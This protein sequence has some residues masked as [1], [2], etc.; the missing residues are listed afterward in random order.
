MFKYDGGEPGS[1]QETAKKNSRKEEMQRDKFLE[2]NTSF[3]MQYLPG[4]T[5]KG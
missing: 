5:L 4:A 1:L 2:A 3:K